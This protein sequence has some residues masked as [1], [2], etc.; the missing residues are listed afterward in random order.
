MVA[1]YIVD[2]SAWIEYF[3][4][5]DAGRQVR[6]VVEAPNQMVLAPE[7]VVA[8]LKIWALLAGK[9]FE[10][11]YGVV[12]NIAIVEP[13]H[14]EE[15][16]EAAQIRQEMRA[17]KDRKDFGIIDALLVAKQRRHHARIVTGDPHFKGLKDVVF[18]KE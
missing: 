5:T 10:P 18:I 6:Q 17:Q 4:G 16:L 14:L 12:R 3:E 1:S 8:E 11:F 7:C 13:I 2:T 15:W 9:E